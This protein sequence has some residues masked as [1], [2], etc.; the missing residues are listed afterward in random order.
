MTCLEIDNTVLILL[1]G[2]Q[3]LDEKEKAR[4]RLGRKGFTQVS[5][6][7]KESHPK[8]SVI[9]HAHLSTFHPGTREAEG[10]GTQ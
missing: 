5:L 3:R 10:G 6:T 4:S 9:E 1:P 8:P 2:H 7:Q